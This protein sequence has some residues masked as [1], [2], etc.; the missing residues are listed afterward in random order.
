MNRRPADVAPSHGDQTVG[1]QDVDRFPQRGRAHAELGEQTFL[2]RQ[3]I[4][5][6]EPSR[7]DVFPQ[8]GGHDLGHSRLANALHDH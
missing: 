1:F 7:Q 5:F 2:R 6:L 4:A 3:H 8:P